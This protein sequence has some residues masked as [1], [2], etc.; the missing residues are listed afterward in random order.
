MQVDSKEIGRR[1]RELR[2]KRGITG[3]FLCSQMGFKARSSLTRIEN[4]EQE[5]TLAQAAKIAN[6]IGVDISE[7]LCD[8]KLLETRKEVVR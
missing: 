5:L 1:V 7:L 6:I 2:T 8:Q 3:S 4:G